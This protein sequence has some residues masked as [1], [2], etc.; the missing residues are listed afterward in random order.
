MKTKKEIEAYIKGIEINRGLAF[1]N[2][3]M[4]MVGEYDA[5]IKILRWVIGDK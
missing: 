3:E 5:Q 4:D 2:D 1:I